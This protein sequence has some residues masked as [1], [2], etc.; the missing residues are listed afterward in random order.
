MSRM[1]YLFWCG[2]AEEKWSRS[3]LWR[4]ADLRLL[5]KIETTHEIL[6]TIVR[7]CPAQHGMAPY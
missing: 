1:T 5:P 4:L 3:V 7:D 6:E 2:L